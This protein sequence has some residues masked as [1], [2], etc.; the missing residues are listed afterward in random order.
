MPLIP[1]QR[2]LVLSL[3]NGSAASP[4]SECER[5]TAAENGAE[6]IRGREVPEGLG[7]AGTAL[8]EV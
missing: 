5:L 4:R 2:P 8:L 3:S 1:L 7:S 6:R